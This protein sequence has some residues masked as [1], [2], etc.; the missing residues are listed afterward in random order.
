[1]TTESPS[2]QHSPNAQ[3]DVE[4]LEVQ[5]A[6]SEDI[7]G[8][9]DQVD[10]EPNLSGKKEEVED[11]GHDEDIEKTCP[12]GYRTL[13]IGVHRLIYSPPPPLA[14]AFVPRFDI[15][16]RLQSLRETTPSVLWLLREMYGLSPAKSL[17][18]LSLD[19]FHAL[20]PT[21]SM[22]LSNRMLNKVSFYVF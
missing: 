15:T 11:G 12:E 14:L 5:P 8:E 10:T 3:A 4:L 17:A 21:A 16:G 20:Q 19:L 22:Y 7:G 2:A 9:H 6:K 18:S 13:V 1:M